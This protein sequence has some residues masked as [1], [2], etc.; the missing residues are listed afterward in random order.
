MQI[1][2]QNVDPVPIPIFTAAD[3]ICELS[4]NIIIKG[5]NATDDCEYFLVRCAEIEEIVP[6]Q[7]E[8]SRLYG[9]TRKRRSL[10]KGEESLTEHES[11]GRQQ[12]S[13][14]DTKWVPLAIN[15]K[16]HRMNDTAAESRWNG[17]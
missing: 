15:T 5:L 4:S 14:G 10:A 3:S 16:G 8:T 7:G 11:V 1:G 9:T 17:R 6:K 13:T 12:E 2:T